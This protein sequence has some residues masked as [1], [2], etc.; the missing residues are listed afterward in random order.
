[1][2]VHYR[3]KHD[4]EYDKTVAKIG[5]NH[6]FDAGYSAASLEWSSE[7]PSEPGWYGLRIDESGK[8]NI[9][10]IL[11]KRDGLW[12]NNWPLSEFMISHSQCIWTQR[13]ILP[14]LPTERKD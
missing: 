1:M 6:G 14:P 7:P 5:W 12:L 8:P 2:D 4:E 9:I 13:I 10:L 3:R 11:E